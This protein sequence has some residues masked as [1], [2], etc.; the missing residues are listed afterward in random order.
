M[1]RILF[2]QNFW[3]EYLGTMVLSARLKQAGHDVELL[4]ESDSGRIRNYIGM[5]RPDVIGMYVVSGSH[6]W[7]LSTLCEIKR[8][9]RVFTLLGGPHPTY[10]PEVIQESCVDAICI[11]E[12]DESVVELCSRFDS[13]ED[14]SSI[15]NI[16]VKRDRSII[17]NPVR[18]LVED[19]DSLP[20]PDRELYYQ[21]PIL[22][23][24]P[25]KHFITGRGCP[26]NCSFCCNKAYKTLYSGKGRMV[27]RVA[28]EKVCREITMV[29]ER[30]PLK[31]VRFDDEVFLLEPP[32]L[33]EF[34]E[35]YR[36]E[37]NIP[38][39]CLIRADLATEDLVRA[40]KS[41]GCYVAYFGI[42]SG[43]DRIRNQ[44]LGK[45]IS[46]QQINDTADLLRKYRIKIGTFNMVGMPGETFEN[47]WETVRLNQEIGSDYPWCSIIQ[48]YPGTD[49]EREAKAAGYLDASYGVNDLTQSYFNDSVIA[50]QDS[51]SL[52]VL[53]KLFYL[54]VKFPIF[55]GWVRWMARRGRKSVLNRWLF[56]LTYAYRYSRTYRM[57]VWR[58]FR[59]ALLWK[60]NY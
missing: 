1:A 30:Y 56:N 55:S 43:N 12:G 51:E 35:R 37:V 13:N 38:F 44:I 15:Q 8:K 36:K 53:Q 6:A 45:N 20:F 41:A 19:L 5:Y 17:Q 22:R 60:D 23:N 14:L 31:T 33:F 54:A 11:G 7:A 26:Y 34:L 40:M 21:Y 27:R 2:L 59:R 46:R 32:W 16:W 49:L 48:P 24:S 29:R 4:I 47:A 57:P 42:E 52:I 18:P 3:F 9:H 28:P 58:L 39:S 10:Y 50:N 25:S